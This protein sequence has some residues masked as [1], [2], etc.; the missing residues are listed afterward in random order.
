MVNGPA[1][2]TGDLADSYLADSQ[3]AYFGFT[4]ATG[5][6]TNLQQVEVDGLDATLAGG[7]RVIFGN[8]FL[9]L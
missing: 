7:T 3:F 5:G 2:L 1:T 9:D 6:L 8:D 4:G